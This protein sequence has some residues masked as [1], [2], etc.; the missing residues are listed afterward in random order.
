MDTPSDVEDCTGIACAFVMTSVASSHSQA[1]AGRQSEV[2]SLQGVV[3]KGAQDY[4]EE[5]RSGGLTCRVE[6]RDARG[7][8]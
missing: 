1:D 5:G 8:F 7:R 3:G 2:A 4:D 6:G